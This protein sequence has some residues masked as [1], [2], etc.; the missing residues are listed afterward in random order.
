[1]YPANRSSRLIV[2]NTSYH[3]GLVYFYLN[4]C[5]ICTANTGWDLHLWWKDA[6]PH[7]DVVFLVHHGH[8]L[9]SSHMSI[10]PW[11]E[12]TQPGASGD[13]SL[14][15]PSHLTMWPGTSLVL[16]PVRVE[17]PLEARRCSIWEPPGR[18]RQQEHI[19]C[20]K[21]GKWPLEYF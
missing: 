6:Q 12:L 19:D 21:P 13:L 18:W 10:P 2:S 17:Q 5:V 1:M 14:R 16:M 15:S 9:T 7:V 20:N 11:P 4:P 8:L 3:S